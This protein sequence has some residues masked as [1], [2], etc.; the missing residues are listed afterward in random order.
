MKQ[1]KSYST[2]VAKYKMKIKNCKHTLVSI[3]VESYSYKLTDEITLL[4]FARN[5]LLCKITSFI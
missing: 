4:R 2:E 5:R 3:S 1:I